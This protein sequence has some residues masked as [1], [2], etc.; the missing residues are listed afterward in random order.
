[1]QAPW[2]NVD[3]DRR[4]WFIPGA[5]SKNKRSYRIFLSDF[6]TALLTE[7]RIL[8]GHPPWLFPHRKDVTQHAPIKDVGNA[9]AHRQA[10]DGTPK[11]AIMRPINSSLLLSGGRWSLHDLRR[12]GATYMQALGVM[13]IVIERCLNRVSSLDQSEKQLNRQLMLALSSVPVRARDARRVAGTRGVSGEDLQ[14]RDTSTAES[15]LRRL[16]PRLR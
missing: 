15:R 16:R 11:K 6:S 4:T 1:M 13:P 5:H 12:T 3:F 10:D 7:L 2:E 14:G 8:T 9:L